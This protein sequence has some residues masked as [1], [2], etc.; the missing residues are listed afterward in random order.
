MTFFHAKQDCSDL[1]CT[2]CDANAIGDLT[3]SLITCSYNGEVGQFLLDRLHHV[4]PNLLPHQV[5]LLN[6]DVE[7]DKQLPLVYLIASVL[8]QVWE[9][10][11]QKKACQLYSVRATL[12][13]GLNILRKSRYSEAADEISS[14]IVGR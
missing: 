8:S 7:H 1:E 12:E 9:C 6:F 2:L 14:I 13:A 11:G 4:L 3:H 10:R 5:I